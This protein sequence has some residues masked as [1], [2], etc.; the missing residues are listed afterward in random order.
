VDGLH[1]G[2]VPQ[3]LLHTADTMERRKEAGIMKVQCCQ[4]KRIRVGDQWM[5]NHAAL[6]L[7]AS[8]TYCPVCASA[9]SIEIFDFHASR[10]SLQDC[11]AV[12]RLLYAAY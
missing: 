8:H 6:I 5:Q 10:A 1:V 12:D 3:V 9:A 4:C 7:G 2:G 11:Q